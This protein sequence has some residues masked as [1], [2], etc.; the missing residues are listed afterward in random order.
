MTR[1]LKFAGA[2]VSA[3]LYAVITIAMIPFAAA[4]WSLACV[5]RGLEW[6]RE[7]VA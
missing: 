7:R 6:A 5:A 2:I 1:A 3:L 4:I